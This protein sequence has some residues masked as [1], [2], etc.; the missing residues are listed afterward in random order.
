ME[1]RCKWMEVII[2][3]LSSV[4]SSS[5]SADQ[6]GGCTNGLPSSVDDL[7][8]CGKDAPDDGEGKR[9]GFAGPTYLRKDPTTQK[10]TSAAGYMR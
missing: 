4:S 8:I 1:A 2:G 7:H 10:V 6:G 3:D 9:L 5:F